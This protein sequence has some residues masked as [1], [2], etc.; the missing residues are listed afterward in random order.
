MSGFLINALNSDFLYLKMKKNTSTK[1]KINSFLNQPY[2]Y[3]YHGKL[4]WIISGILFVM[5]WAFNYFFEPFQVYVPEHKMDY[6]WISFV[7]AITAPVILIFMS[8]LNSRKFV[9]EKW[10]IK[11]EIYFIILFLFLVGIGQFLIRD[12]IYDNP[13]N[14]SIKYLFEEIRNTFLVGSLFISILIPLNFA[15]LNAKHIKNAHLLNQSH[16][17]IKLSPN[18][19]IEIPTNL[20]TETITLDVNKFVFA[21]AEGNYVELFILKD[22]ITKEVKRLTIKELESNLQP[23][24]N[25]IKTHRSYL[26]NMMHIKDVSGNA[27]GYRLKLLDLAQSIPVSRNMISHFNSKMKE[28]M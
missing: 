19:I 1:F 21:K 15:R 10:K 3:Y 26:V 17:I 7:H 12:V 23:F 5:S 16:D 14:W 20:K 28:H 25:I 8:L 27:Q 6:F 11:Y 9:D 2:P 13:N 22:K 24:E 18:S 4:V